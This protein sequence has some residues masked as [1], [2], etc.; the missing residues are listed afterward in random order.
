MKDPAENNQYSITEKIRELKENGQSQSYNCCTILFSP[1]LKEKKSVS[2]KE[3]IQGNRL[4]YIEMY[5]I[6]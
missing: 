1:S 6:C 5:V 2:K 3:N 4:Y